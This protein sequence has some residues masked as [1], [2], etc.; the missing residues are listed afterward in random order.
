VVIIVLMIIIGS[1]VMLSVTI[2]PWVA[3]INRDIDVSDVT[4]EHN[5]LGDIILETFKENRGLGKSEHFN[6]SQML[7]EI[8]NNTAEIERLLKNGTS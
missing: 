7:A 6:Q 5:A 1:G 8:V 2:V 4:D 3:E